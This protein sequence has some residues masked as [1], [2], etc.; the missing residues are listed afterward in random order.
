[1]LLNNFVIKMKLN[2]FLAFI[3]YH[4]P[5]VELFQDKLLRTCSAD[6]SPGLGLL[7]GKRLSAILSLSCSP[8]GR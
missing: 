7:A 4:L 5:T 6:S 3:R 1:M 8:I 2:N